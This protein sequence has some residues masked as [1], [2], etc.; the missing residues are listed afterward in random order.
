MSVIYSVLC[1]NIG[2]RTGYFNELELKH[3]FLVGKICCQFFYLV[4][5]SLRLFF[6]VTHLCSKV[7]FVSWCS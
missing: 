5:I 7:V 6:Y 1:W 4:F 3:Q 2:V